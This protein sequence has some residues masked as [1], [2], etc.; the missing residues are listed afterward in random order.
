MSGG[1]PILSG[2]F[3]T[4]TSGA[5]ALSGGCL[6]GMLDGMPMAPGDTYFIPKTAFATS[7]VYGVWA[8]C[9]VAASG[10]GRLYWEMF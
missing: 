3:M 6:S 5:M 1:G 8:M 9:D 2:N 7:G 4:I 10:I